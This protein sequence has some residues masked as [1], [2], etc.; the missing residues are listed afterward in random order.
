M[1]TNILLG[2]ETP[3]DA[4]DDR[5]LEAPPKEPNEVPIQEPDVPNKKCPKL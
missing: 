4:P 1:R 2:D 5:P 3:P